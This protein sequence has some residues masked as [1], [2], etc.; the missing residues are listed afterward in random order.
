M[1]RRPG[2]RGAPLR[3]L[4]L[5]VHA[6]LAAQR[7]LQDRLARIAGGLGSFL[8]AGIVASA[9]RIRQAGAAGGYSERAISSFMIS[10]VPP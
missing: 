9:A 7:G 2:A 6:A 5:A 4:R 1:G 3:L 8:H 10:L